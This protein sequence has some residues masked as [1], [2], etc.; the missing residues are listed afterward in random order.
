MYRKNEDRI[1]IF[2]DEETK[3]SEG[4]NVLMKILFN[5]YRS[6]SEERGERPMSQIAFHRKLSERNIEIEGSGSRAVVQKKILKPREIGSSEVDW[7]TV[8]RLANNY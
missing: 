6:W 3:E 1:G 2:L 8:T 5:V 7:N 4:G